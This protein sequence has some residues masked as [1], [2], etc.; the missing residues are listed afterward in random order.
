M[1]YDNKKQSNEK[2]IISGDLNI[3]NVISHFSLWRLPCNVEVEEPDEDAIIKLLEVLLQIRR[4]PLLLR[5][6]VPPK[7]LF[8]FRL[9]LTKTLL[10]LFMVRWW[11]LW[12][13]KRFSWS[14]L[15][16]LKI[17]K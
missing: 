8:R 1:I 6:L 10:R 9:L 11:L 17:K 2:G 4:L 13:F 3:L 16:A 5:L 7:L 12:L 15:S 14:L